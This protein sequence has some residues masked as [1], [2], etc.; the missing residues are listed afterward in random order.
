EPL[1]FRSD[2]GYHLR[3]GRAGADHGDALTGQI[4]LMVP[5]SRVELRSAEGV[6]PLPGGVLGV[7]EE[8]HRAHHHIEDVSLT[9]RCGE[10]LAMVVFVPTH[11][12]HGGTNA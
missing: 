12:L 3:S 6:K 9:G 4:D 1:D 10:R 7:A 2:G 8:T 5:M 11:A